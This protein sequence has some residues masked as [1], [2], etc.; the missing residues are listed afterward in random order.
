MEEILKNYVPLEEYQKN[1]KM[2]S[3]KGCGKIPENC[4]Y[5]LTK[6]KHLLCENC[7]KKILL[8]KGEKCLICK[9]TIE[10]GSLTKVAFSNN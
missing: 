6:C 1:F 3:C 5:G 8:E 2:F 9:A 7:L 10:K 4:R